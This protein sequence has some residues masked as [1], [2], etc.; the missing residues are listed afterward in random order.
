MPV[1]SCHNHSFFNFHLE[2]ENV[3][4]GGET[5]TLEYL[6]N[7]KNF[8]DE[9]ILKVFFKLFKCFQP[10]LYLG[11]HIMLTRSIWFD[12][13]LCNGSMGIV[14]D[15]IYKASVHQLFLWLL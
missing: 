4:E 14:R 10:V 3:G 6:E 9:I 13:G 5:H 11:V 12:K 2:S 8:L 15:I 7:K 1:I